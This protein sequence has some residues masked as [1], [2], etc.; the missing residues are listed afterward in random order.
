MEKMMSMCCIQRGI[1][2]VHL[3][4]GKKYNMRVYAVVI[5]HID[6]GIKFY[7]FESVH[8]RVTASE[9]DTKSLEP[10]VRIGIDGHTFQAMA[11]DLEGDVWDNTI[12][13]QIRT[14]V[15]DVCS[16]FEWPRTRKST[17]V[18]F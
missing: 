1:E 12:L 2:D 11:H 5:N 17:Q 13:P 9:Y 15:H 10:E 3:Y 16:S 6:E 4:Q 7:V 14:A 8:M 18:E